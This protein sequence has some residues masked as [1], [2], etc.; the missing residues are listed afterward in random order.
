MNPIKDMATVT[1]LYLT[2]C[3]F[4]SDMTRPLLLQTS[5]HLLQEDIGEHGQS[6]EA[7]DGSGAHELIVIQAKLFPAI[8][9][10]NFDIPASRDMDKQGLW[11]SLQIAGSE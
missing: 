5:M 6:P 7:Q 10:E 8:A 11:I 1:A 4:N 9:K 3:L 2:A